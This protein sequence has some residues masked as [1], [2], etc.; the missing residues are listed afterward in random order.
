MMTQEILTRAK[1][2]AAAPW[3]ESAR[4]NEAL[5]RMADALEQNQEEIL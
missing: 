5:L 3:L 4:K 2:A 1:A